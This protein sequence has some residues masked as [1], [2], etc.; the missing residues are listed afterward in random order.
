MYPG[1]Q[2]CACKYNAVMST[3]CDL[4]KCSSFITYNNASGNMACLTEVI[5]QNM[6]SGN[7]WFYTL[8][9]ED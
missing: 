2:F 8:Q 6:D 3:V 1:F 5:R 9:C 7:G 4:L